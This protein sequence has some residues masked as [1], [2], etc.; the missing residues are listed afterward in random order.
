MEDTMSK[1]A[2]VGN[3]WVNLVIGII[4][5]AIACY[6]NLLPYSETQKTCYFVGALLLLISSILEKQLFFIVLQIIITSG[7]G[8]AFA[9]WIPTFKATIPIILSLLAIVYFT[10]RGQLQDKTTILGII[11]IAVLA[12][13]YAVTKPFVYFLGAV[14]LMAYSFISFKQGIKIALLWA[15]LNAVFAIT[16]ILNLLKYNF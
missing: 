6:G 14:L 2:R 16:A 11:A 3:Y 5:M 8:I 15:I 9:V 7:T 4:G 10:K 13:G 12:A 1:N